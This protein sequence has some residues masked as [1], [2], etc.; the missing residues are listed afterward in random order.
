MEDVK[1]KVLQEVLKYASTGWANELKAKYKPDPA[2]PQPVAD[3]APADDV[4]ISDLSIL[5]DL[6]E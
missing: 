4:D 5:G 6:G 2:Q 1:K 3:E